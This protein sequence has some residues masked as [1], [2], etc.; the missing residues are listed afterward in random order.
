MTFPTRFTRT[1]D[2]YGH[3]GMTRLRQAGVVVVGLGGVGAHAAV[4]LARSGIGRLH[5]IDF[6]TVTTSSLNRHP[7]AGPDDVGRT[8]VDVLASFF[9]STCPDTIVTTEASRLTAAN[10][11]TLLPA[12]DTEAFGTVIDAIDAVPDKVALLVHAMVQGRRT[13]CSAGAAGKIDPGG[14]CSGSLADTRVCPLARKV[15]K[16]VREADVDPTDIVAV[17]SEE[18]PRPPIESPADEPHLRRRQPS[19]MMLPGMVGYAL[20]A[21]AVALVARG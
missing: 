10:L 15:R 3:D 11:P 19:N 8:K 17:W 21:E 1:V 7:V 2:L 4:A 18:A 14:L 16:G 9:A 6:D 12:A 13:I 20:A 5:L